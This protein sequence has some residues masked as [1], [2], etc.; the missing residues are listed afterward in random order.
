MSGYETKRDCTA[1]AL[2]SLHTEDA[3]RGTNFG[4]VHSDGVYAL[5]FTGR[6]KRCPYPFFYRSCNVFKELEFEMRW[7]A[8]TWHGMGWIRV[9]TSTL[10]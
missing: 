9:G 5:I 10:R 3:S 4:R 2:H 6:M 7:M 8:M 1:V